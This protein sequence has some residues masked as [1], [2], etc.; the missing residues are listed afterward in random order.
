LEKTPFFALAAVSGFVTFIVQKS[1]GAVR[2]LEIYPFNIRITN[3]MVSYFRYISKMIWPQNLAVFYPHLGQSLPMWQSVLAGLLLV[4]VSIVVIRAGRRQPYLPV[5]W[6]WYV[7]TL[8]PV[9]GL[10]QVGAQAM[11]DRY[12]YVPLIGL[13]IMIAW[14]VSDLVGSQR[15]GKPALTLAAASLLSALIVSTF[16]QVKHWKNSLTLLEHTLSVTDRNYLA[17][18]NLGNAIAELGRIEEAID[19]FTE[20]VNIRP[21]FSK[22][23]NNLGNALSRQGKNQEAIRH[24]YKA[25]EVEPNFP[26]FHLNLGNALENQGKIEGAISHYSKAL[27]LKPDFAEAYFN[28]G[29]L[30]AKHGKM[31]EAISHFSTALQIKP[32][33]A[34]AHN[35]LGVVLAYVGRN[36]EAIAHFNAALR[37]KPGFIRAHNNLSMALRQRK[38]TRGI[39]EDNRKPES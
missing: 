13:F 38:K 15:Y 10:V 26:G 1:G 14:G 23:H 16:L 3:A 35:S 9:I 11:A 18:N 5:G 8:V 24:F 32:D 12:T 30:L 21:N 19:H 25:L 31:D 28:L 37:I 2:A 27:Q 36:E 34:E 39:A 17:H 4:V 20:A 29:N 22:A 7:G 33:F 6:F